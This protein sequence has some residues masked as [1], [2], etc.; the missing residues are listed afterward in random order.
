MSFWRTC[1]S[2]YFAT[3]NRFLFSWATVLAF[4]LT[5]CVTHTCYLF[6]LLANVCF[7][8]R[9]YGS[10]SVGNPCIKNGRSR[11]DSAAMTRGRSSRTTPCRAA[12]NPARTISS[13]CQMVHGLVTKNFVSTIIPC[14]W[15]KLGGGGVHRDTRP[16][17][18]A[19]RGHL[20]FPLTQQ[21]S[22]VNVYIVASPLKC[23]TQYS[24]PASWRSY[25]D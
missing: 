5:L 25:N 8:N 9:T 21:Y 1:P 24:F 20:H 12:V 22:N 16:D 6:F 18:P 11:P 13:I 4:S 14:L 2:E 17:E 3:R 23:E 19:I 15:S 7:W 10:V